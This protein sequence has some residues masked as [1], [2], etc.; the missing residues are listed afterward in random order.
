M[1][2]GSKVWSRARATIQRLL[3]ADEPILRDNDALRQRALIP[4]DDVQMHLPAKVGDYTDFYSS[5]EHATN[6]G[7]M[8]RGEDNALQPNW[9]HLP[10][11]YHGRASSIVTSGTDVRRPS[12]QLQVDVKD[13]SKGSKHGPCRVL[14][15]E[16]E[17]ASIG[18]EQRFVYQD[19]IFGVVL[20][21]D[22]SARD[23]QKWEYIP[24]GPFGSKNFA[25]TISPWVVPLAALEPFRCEPSFGPAQKDPVPLAY[26]SDPNYARGTYD[27]NLKVSVKPEDSEQAYTVTKSNFRNMYWN[28]KQQ[29]V[30]HTVTGCNMQPGDLL[31]SG[32]ISGSTDESMGSM[33]ELSW[34]G[35]REV[36]LGDSGLTRKFLQDGDTV[37]I[38][39]FCQGHGYRIGFGSCEG[40]ILPAHPCNT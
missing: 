31:G 17:M 34:Q 1:A 23:I 26:I 16:L 33:L 40:K 18:H 13:P 35:T 12:G 5:R 21:N 3:S 38:T 19:H 27:I 20:M 6:V 32:T 10:V 24:L 22:W 11:G 7:R 8:F 9:L 29:L 4:M 28:M 36:A 2:Q 25:T 14:D 15:Y 30:H 37:A 39:G